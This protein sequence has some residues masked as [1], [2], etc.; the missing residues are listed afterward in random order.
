MGRD[1]FLGPG[2]GQLLGLSRTGYNEFVCK[3]FSQSKGIQVSLD[4]SDSL[5]WS[6]SFMS[7]PHVQKEGLSFENSSM[8]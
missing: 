3:C 6:A 1:D 7:Q 4:R 2:S 5:L 8:C